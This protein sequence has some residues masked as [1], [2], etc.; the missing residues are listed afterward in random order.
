MKNRRGGSDVFFE[1]D[2]EPR[3]AEG[4]KNVSGIPKALI[5]SKSKK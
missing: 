5:P 3:L 1:E 2:C 4:A